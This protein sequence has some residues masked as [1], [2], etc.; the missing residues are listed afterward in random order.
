M[1]LKEKVWMALLAAALFLTVGAKYSPY[2]PGDVA[3]TRFVQGITPASTG[4]A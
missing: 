1:V 2:F 3:V 4:W